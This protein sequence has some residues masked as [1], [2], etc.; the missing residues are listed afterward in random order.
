MLT[1]QRYGLGKYVNSEY[2]DKWEIYNI[3]KYCDTLVSDGEGGLEP[4]FTCNLYI[5]SQD[6]A[7]KVLSDMA[8]VFKGMFYY[9]NGFIYAINDMPEETPIYSFTNSN[10]VD[11]NFN[12]ESTSLK[13]RNSAVYV[14][15]IDKNNFYKPAVEYVENIEA[16]RKFGFKETELTAFGCTSR[17]QAQ[18]LGIAV[19]QR[20]R[21]LPI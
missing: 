18:R 9:S 15:Y 6:D 12:Y 1:N 2:T 13:D 20:Q 5:Q 16:V 11:G 21:H 14:R 17:G 3:A 4:R 10:V 19:S 8:S 7:L